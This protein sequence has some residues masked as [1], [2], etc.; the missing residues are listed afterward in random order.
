[1]EAA[2]AQNRLTSPKERI[3]CACNQRV[4]RAA[5]IGRYSSQ[6]KHLQSQDQQTLGT[7]HVLNPIQRLREGY[8]T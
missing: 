6:H 1:M 5:A 2:E 8:T 7:F 4:E 3:Q